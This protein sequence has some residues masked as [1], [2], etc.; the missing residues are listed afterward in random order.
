LSEPGRTPQSRALR[1]ALLVLS[2][3]T[4]I[5]W[6]AALVK[7]AFAAIGPAAASSWRFFLGAIVLL[8]ITRPKL[9]AWTAHQWLG[10]FA[11]GATTALMNQTF[12]QAIARIPLGSSTAI[13]YMGPFLVAALAKRSLRHFAFVALAGLGVLALTRPGGGITLAGALFAAVAG[14][15]WAAYTFASHRVGGNT[16]G[17]GG[18]AVAMA[19]ASLLTLPFGLGAT[20]VVLSH[21]SLL[22]RLL[23][24]GV[25]ATVLGFGVEMQ[26]LR[27][28]KPSIVSV[29]L[30][31]DPAVAFFIGW[32]LLHEHVTAWDL[33]GLACVVL[34]GIGVTYDVAK[35]D[36]K[37]AL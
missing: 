34:A 26:A 13:E 30:A 18:L 11:L 14:A 6:S 32:I 3:A 29:L 16:E 4:M 1:G 20:H 33:M 31:L 23:L 36:I 12:Y 17:F 19:L 24:V 15:S 35:E 2:G 5:Q 21:P 27:H 28:L 37:A 7:P 25:M 22:G 10:A 9:R 8:I